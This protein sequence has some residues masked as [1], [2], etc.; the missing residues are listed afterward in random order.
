L[1][2]SKLP[3]FFIPGKQAFIGVFILE[4]NPSTVVEVKQRQGQI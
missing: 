1:F 3:Y 2:G 4:C